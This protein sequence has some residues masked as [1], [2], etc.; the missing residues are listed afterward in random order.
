MI[1]KHRQ[2]VKSFSLDQEAAK[3]ALNLF[4]PLKETEQSRSA[5]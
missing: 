4:K 5:T 3:K 1:A 2:V